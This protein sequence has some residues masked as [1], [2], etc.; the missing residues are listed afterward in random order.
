MS[1]VV[2]DGIVWQPGGDK[3]LWDGVE[4]WKLF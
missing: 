3:I 1:K 2:D 4:E